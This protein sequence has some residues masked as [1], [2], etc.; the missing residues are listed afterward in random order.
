ML[1]REEQ[2]AIGENMITGNSP[3]RIVIGYSEF[4]QTISDPSSQ[5]R[6]WLIKASEIIVDPA[7]PKDFR[8]QRMAR[9]HVH[10]VDLIEGMDKARLQDHQLIARKRY[11]AKM[12]IAG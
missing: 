9:L 12:T 7:P 6:A 2:R 1:F 5:R 4:I 8:F 3:N 10:L 11:T